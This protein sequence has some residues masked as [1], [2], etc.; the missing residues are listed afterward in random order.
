MGVHAG[1]GSHLEEH[2]GQLAVRGRARERLVQL[3]V[4]GVRLARVQRHV[5]LGIRLA[6]VVEP[7]VPLPRPVD[8]EGQRAIEPIRVVV[9]TA[10]AILPHVLAIRAV[11][12][13][14][15]IPL[16]VRDRIVVSLGAGRLLRLQRPVIEQVEKHRW[17]G[18][19]KGHVDASLN[20]HPREHRVPLHERAA[21][22]MP[23]DH[24]L[25][26]VRVHFG[27]GQRPHQLV[28]HLERRDRVLACRVGAD[29]PPLQIVRVLWEATVVLIRVGR[30][31]RPG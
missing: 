28:H 3:L 1:Q 15:E 25:L 9:G 20:I 29:R 22:P 17:I 26:H 19:V 5:L 8:I 18:H 30:P 4:A 12:Q 6:D 21:F 11:P 13:P 10:D 14:L 27:V 2:V 7:V 23:N 24:D 31:G 16:P